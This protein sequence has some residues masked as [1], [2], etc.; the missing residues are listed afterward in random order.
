M[1]YSEFISDT[2]CGSG[3]AIKDAF[4]GRGQN[5]I[6]CPPGSFCNIHPADR[7]AICCVNA[8]TS[9]PTNKSTYADI[10]GRDCDIEGC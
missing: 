3:I 10:D 9:Q 1:K 5:T 8:P 6:T 2:R 4:C 7:Y